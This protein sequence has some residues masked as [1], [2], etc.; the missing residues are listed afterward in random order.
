MDMHS[1]FFFFHFSK[2]LNIYHEH[3]F[4]QL[5]FS[6][7]SSVNSNNMF[8]SSSSNPESDGLITAG[9]THGLYSFCLCYTI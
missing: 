4:R 1:V 5:H 6:L 9:E 2:Y 3:I 7:K 8:W